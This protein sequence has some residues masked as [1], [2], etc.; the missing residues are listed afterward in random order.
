MPFAAIAV[1][2]AQLALIYFFAGHD[3]LHA[4]RGDD[5]PRTAIDHVQFREI[6]PDAE[7]DEQSHDREQASAGPAGSHFE[8]SRLRRL[9]EPQIFSRQ[10]LAAG[11]GQMFGACTHDLY[12]GSETEGMKGCSR[13]ET[14]SCSTPVPSG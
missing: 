12:R 10:F 13:S 9:H 8:R 7:A 3:D 5:L 6:S 14:V 11:Q 2:R 1:L 4:R